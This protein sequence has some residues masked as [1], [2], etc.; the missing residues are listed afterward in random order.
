MASH[1]HRPLLYISRTT[2]QNSVGLVPACQG[3]PPQHDWAQKSFWLALEVWNKEVWLNTDFNLA[4][5]L[6]VHRTYS[7]FVFLCCLLILDTEEKNLILGAIAE[8]NTNAVN[9]AVVPRAVEAD[10]VNIQRGGPGTG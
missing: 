3:N 2:A 9:F 5:T 7:P 4:Y 1:S 6:S 8:I 10:F